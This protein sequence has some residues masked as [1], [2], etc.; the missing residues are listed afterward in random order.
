MSRTD[1]VPVR[2]SSPLPQV[3]M[4]EPVRLAPL[5]RDRATPIHLAP[6]EEARAAIAVFLGIE[7]VD[8][9]AF[10]GAIEPWGQHGWA[11]TGRLTATAWQACV[12]TLEP[13]REEVDATVTRQFLPPDEIDQDAEL[14][15]DEEDLDMPEPADEAID[16][17]HLVVEALALELEP[18][19]RADGAAFGKR[20]FSAPGVTPLTDEAMRPFASLAALK[21]KLGGDG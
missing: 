8:A 3:P 10:E 4:S 14:E 21:E 5:P 18:Y 7:A 6:D 11:V 12:V 9:L 16:L 19:P 1:M 13:V 15:L 20:V 17:A 2:E